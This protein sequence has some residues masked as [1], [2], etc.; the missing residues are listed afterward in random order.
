MRIAYFSPLGPRRTGIA[1]YSEEL[2]PYL[3]RRAEIDLFVDGYSPSNGDLVRQF[4]VHDYRELLAGQR[5]PEHDVLLYQ[6][7]NSAAHEYIYRMLSRFPGVTVLHDHVLHHL[8]AEIT[9]GRGDGA[10][11]IRE[12]AYCHGPA[13]GAAARRAVRRARDFPYLEYPA[14]RRV[15]DASLGVIVHSHY[16]RSLLTTDSPSTEIAVVNHHVVPV[17]PPIDGG[18]T[19][20]GLGLGQEDVLFASFGLATPEKRLDVALRAYRCA[21]ERLPNSRYL[22][23]GDILPGYEL[24]RLVA[25]LGLEDAVTW[26][27]YVEKGDLL[28][29]MAATDVGICLRWPTMGETSGT[30]LRLMGAGKPTVVSAVGWFAELP[31]DCCWQIGVGKEEEGLLTQAMLALGLDAQR[32]R[33]MGERALR[34]VKEHHSAERSAEEYIRFLTRV[35][36]SKEG[37]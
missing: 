9:M 4:P 24:R 7:G 8:I 34:H 2:L 25:S 14:N 33:G 35:T 29:Y 18:D 1:D 32:R 3:G 10:S 22:I 21:R 11:Y 12:L 17:E 16:V 5:A 37:G 23:V 20:R 28:R 15:L 6:M 13:G 27:G 31:S 36:E 26:L 30:V 19:R